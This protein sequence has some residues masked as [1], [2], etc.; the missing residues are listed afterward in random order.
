MHEKFTKLA[1]NEVYSSIHSWGKTYGEHKEYLEFSDKE[2]LELQRYAKTIGIMFTASAMDQISLEKLISF[3]VPFIKIGSGDA[4][5]FKLLRYAATTNIPCVIST[6]MQSEQTVRKIVEI[7]KNNSFCLMHCV[8]SYPT[9]PE[10]I[11]LRMLEY[12]RKQFPDIILGYSGHETGI[13][14]TQAAVILGANVVERHFT[15]DK[16][17]KGSDHCASLTPNEFEDLVLKIRNIQNITHL[18]TK[19]E[20]VIDVIKNMNSQFTTGDEHD[21]IL[22][23]SEVNDKHILKC[24]RNC[25]EKLGKTLVFSKDLNSGHILTELDLNVKVS[26]LKGIPAEYIDNL[27]GQY[28]ITNVKKDSPVYREFLSL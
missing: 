22:A 23:L 4:N 5:N 25:F 18:S 17:Q 15:L 13:I 20:N 10:D 3:D 14:A 6:G 7:F 24:E 8:S 9:S 11:G 28:L 16:T 26:P 1:L 19:T 2:Y 27:I 12:F 21:L